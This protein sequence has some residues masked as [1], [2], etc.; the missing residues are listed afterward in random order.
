M[1]VNTKSHKHFFFICKMSGLFVGDRWIQ[2][3][4]GPTSF[5]FLRP[6]TAN[7]PFFIL[8]G[9][10]HNSFGGQC[11]NCS[12][13]SSIEKCCYRSYDTA[14]LQL[15]DHLSTPTKKVKIFIE[16][17][18]RLINDADNEIKALGSEKFYQRL[19]D[20]KDRVLFQNNP[21]SGEQ[22]PSL[23]AAYQPC[24]FKRR[25]PGAYNKYCPTRNIEWHFADARLTSPRIDK[26]NAKLKYGF[27]H[28]VFDMIL[29]IFQGFENKNYSF[30]PGHEFRNH[31]E[32]VQIVAEVANSN[33]KDVSRM[34]DILLSRTDSLVAKEVRK[35]GL[36]RDKIIA[37]V[38]FLVDSTP[39]VVKETGFVSG[40][41]EILPTI[42]KTNKLPYAAEITKEMIDHS[43]LRMIQITSYILDIYFVCRVIKMNDCW[44]SV[45]CAGNE[46][47]KNISH[48]FTQILKS[49]SL[50]TDLQANRKCVNLQGISINLN[51]EAGLSTPVS[52]FSVVHQNQPNLDSA[53]RSILTRVAYDALANEGVVLPDNLLVAN[54]YIIRN[55]TI[56]DIKDYLELPKFVEHFR[57]RQELDSAGDEQSATKIIQKLCKR[58]S[59]H[60]DLTERDLQ[61]FFKKQWLK[62]IR[63]IANCD[64]VM[65]PVAVTL[66]INANDVLLAHELFNLMQDGIMPSITN[67]Q[68]FVDRILSM[69]LLESKSPTFFK[70]DVFDSYIDILKN[71]RGPIT[72]SPDGIKALAAS[73][74]KFGAALAR[75]E[76]G[77]RF[78][79]DLGEWN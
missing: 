31:L 39:D 36:S 35:A 57:L 26:P 4:S 73:H 19:S 42:L 22:L 60:V 58:T 61:T 53:R 69:L 76:F 43:R 49:H 46:H 32:F 8:L 41:I 47:C 25:D 34:I 2:K 51:K 59:L 67:P 14:F 74:K 13:D 18:S 50:Q 78:E 75:G 6:K 37:F 29:K 33:K 66:A 30:K 5:R 27:E 77:H 71:F 44:L 52:I 28:I 79:N 15:L 48:F 17:F 12:C 10:E 70:Y 54:D 24:F 40:F 11:P 16:A 3:L 62:P 38:Y 65:A 1:P 72:Y 21:K 56:S 23:Y 7:Q 20:M 55:N 63:S 68:T 45:L 64:P 9:D